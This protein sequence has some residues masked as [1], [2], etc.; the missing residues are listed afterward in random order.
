MKIHR[1]TIGGTE[2]RVEFNWN[3]IVA[4]LESSGRDTME[5]LANLSAVRPSELLA[6]AHAG[7]RE[8]EAL[9]G[10]EF[11]LTVEE[12]GRISTTATMHEVIAAFVDQNSNGQADNDAA[13]ADAKKKSAF[14]R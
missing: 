10:R 1:I 8:G 6:L 13:P 4:F 7:I 11:P 9:E 2:Y 3:A 14:R 12:L 5:S